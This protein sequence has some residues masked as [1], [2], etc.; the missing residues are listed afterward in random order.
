MGREE[1]PGE[2]G[3]AQGGVT[4]G[5]FARGEGAA[6]VGQ[7]NFLPGGVCGRAAKDFAK[8][9][10]GYALVTFFDCLHDMGNAVQHGARGK[11]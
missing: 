3:G 5:G 8:A 2:T 11:V 4:G 10:G 6:G 1:G 9:G 7:R